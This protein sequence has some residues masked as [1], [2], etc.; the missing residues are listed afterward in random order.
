MLAAAR[1]RLL[2]WCRGSEVGYRQ[3]SIWDRKI[4]LQEQAAIAV[5]SFFGSDGYAHVFALNEGG[6][7]NHIAVSASEVVD[8]QFIGSAIGM[9]DSKGKLAEQLSIDAV[10]HPSG[11]LRVAVNGVQY[12]QQGSDAPW[13]QVQNSRCTRFLAFKEKLYCALIVKGAEIGSPARSDTTVGFLF[14]FPI[15]YA[16]EKHSDKLVLAAE[17]E[18]VWAIRAVVD[19]AEPF[20]INP[21]FLA[22]IDNAGKIHLLY[23][24]SRGGGFWFIGGGPGAAGAFATGGPS[25]LRFAQV[26]VEDL[27]EQAASTPAGTQSVYPADDLLMINGVTPNEMPFLLGRDIPLIDNPDAWI[28]LRPLNQQFSFDSRSGKFHGLMWGDRVSLDD[29]EHKVAFNLPGDFPRGLDSNWVTISMRNGLWRNRFEVVSGS[30]V[31]RGFCW[32]RDPAPFVRVDPLG[33]VHT[34]LIAQTTGGTGNRSGN[35]SFSCA[36]G[37]LTDQGDSWSAPINLG[38]CKSPWGR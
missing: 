18:G 17:T 28:Q 32:L 5:T 11:T 8:R 4:V 33:S 13:Q 15:W 19:P 22:G 30:D 34:L 20:D 24:G 2:I 6:D 38:R 3:N 1:L 7:I 9:T 31:P 35:A 23:F 25:Y 29:G 21:D 36:I 27:L 14:I 10:E 26:S 16:A 37:Y 12:V